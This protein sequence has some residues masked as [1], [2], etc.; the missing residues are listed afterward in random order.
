MTGY[1]RLLS[2]YTPFL[3]PI[4]ISLADGS[5][6]PAFGKGQ[7][8]TSPILDVLFVPSFPTSLLSISKL[9]QSQIVVSS[10]PLKLVF[11]MM[12]SQGIRL[13]SARLRGNSTVFVHIRVWQQFI[14][15]STLLKLRLCNGILDLVIFSIKN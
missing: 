4:C 5:K 10:S 14:L 13:V 2:T 9:C 1:C 15:L 8:H 7:I 6:T 3:K 11:F 12:Q